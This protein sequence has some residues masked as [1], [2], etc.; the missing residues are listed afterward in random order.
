MSVFAGNF[1]KYRIFFELKGRKRAP[2]FGESS[3]STQ[4]HFLVILL[5][6]RYSIAALGSLSRFCFLNQQL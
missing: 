2:L 3:A 5:H 6:S 1:F 4:G